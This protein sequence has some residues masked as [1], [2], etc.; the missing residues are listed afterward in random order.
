M[1]QTTNQVVYN[2]ACF[3]HILVSERS[4]LLKKK[5]GHASP[6]IDEFPI[7]SHHERTM[8][9]S[10]ISHSYVNHIMVPLKHPFTIWLWLTVRHGKIHHAIKNG[11][12][13]ISIRAMASMAM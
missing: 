2:I 4:L 11:K 9:T 5:H 8:A 6:T 10:G 7:C 1:F 3:S 12:P 13:S